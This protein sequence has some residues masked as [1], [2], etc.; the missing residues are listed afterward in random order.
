MWRWLWH[1]EP[2]VR[3]PLHL[4]HCLRFSEG[5]ALASSLS[6]YILGGKVGA[7]PSALEAP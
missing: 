6:F 7:A 2:F 5:L 4:G 1:T 3:V